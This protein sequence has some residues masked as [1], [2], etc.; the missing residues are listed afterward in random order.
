MP[1][2]VMQEYHIRRGYEPT[3]FERELLGRYDPDTS[4]V[5]AVAT[6]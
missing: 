1:A 2:S 5:P 3:P 4:D 6:A